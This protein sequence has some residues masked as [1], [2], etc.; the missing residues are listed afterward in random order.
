M[1]LSI[2]QNKAGITFRRYLKSSGIVCYK[3]KIE[4][5]G[6]RAAEL[7]NR[8]EAFMNGIT[9]MQR[10]STSYADYGKFANGKK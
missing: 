4:K 10:S 1:R 6:R 3:E 9:S 2:S 8:K 7:E 5:A